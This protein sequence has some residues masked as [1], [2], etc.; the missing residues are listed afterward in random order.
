MASQA[1]NTHGSTEGGWAGGLEGEM[2]K[3]GGGEGIDHWEWLIHQWER[4]SV[5]TYILHV[6][7][8]AFRKPS[9]IWMPA[10]RNPLS[11]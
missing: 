9:P 8:E 5:D 3:V 11:H 7:K 4:S 6:Q 1:Q 10:M 2:D